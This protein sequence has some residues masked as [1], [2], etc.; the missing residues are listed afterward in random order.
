ME[1]KFDYDIAWI[2]QAYLGEYPGSREN[3]DKKFIRAVKSFLAVHKL[4]PRTQLIIVSDGCEITHEI[5]HDKFAKYDC[6]EYAYVSKA[7]KKMYEQR[8]D[9]ATFYRSLPRQVGRTIANKSFLHAFMDSDDLLLPDAAKVIKNYWGTIQERDSHKEYKWAACSEWYENEAMVK[10][11]ANA[12]GN[13]VF[14]DTAKPEKIKGLKSKWV[15]YA[16]NE[17]YK[18]VLSST[19]NI[20]HRWDCKTRWA[21][22]Y[23]NR[24][25]GEPSEDVVY[26]TNIRREG[27]GM[28]IN[29]AIM[30]R[31]HYSGIWDY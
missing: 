1:S 6:I 4:D 21:D 27:D 11:Q 8:D 5:Y 7:K 16:M 30:V 20:I 9:G 22:M 28:I 23:S 13:F 15:R 29:D 18:N 25:K 26:C 2:M 19:W 24:K 12:K 14:K 3:S 10:W 17:P 31:C